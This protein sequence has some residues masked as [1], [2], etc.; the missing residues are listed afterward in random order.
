[1]VSILVTLESWR[2]CQRRRRQ[3]CIRIPPRLL[4]RNYTE[5]TSRTGFLR[6]HA[7]RGS[8]HRKRIYIVNINPFAIALTAFAFALAESRFLRSLRYIV[9]PPQ[10]VPLRWK[11]YR[12]WAGRM[13]RV[14]FR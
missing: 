1:M 13:R 8:I 11:H 14:T 7:P 9:L 4:L 2:I 6:L 3:I 10:W 12:T 5:V